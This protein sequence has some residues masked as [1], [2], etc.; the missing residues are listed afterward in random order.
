M[1]RLKFMGIVLFSFV[2]FA[3]FA[4]NANTLKANQDA[5]PAE[6]PS[7]EIGD[8]WIVEQTKKDI[9]SLTPHWKEP[10]LWR[11]EVKECSEDPN[12]FVLEIGS[13]SGLKTGLDVVYGLNP[14]IVK[15]I[16][17]RIATADGIKVVEQEIN[18]SGPVM[19][20]NSPFSLVLPGFPLENTTSSYVEG[21]NVKPLS[22]SSG[23]SHASLHDSSSGGQMVGVQ[24][25]LKQEVSFPKSDDP[26]MMQGEAAVNGMKGNI[27]NG[28]MDASSKISITMGRKQAL[29]LWSKNAPWALVEETPRIKTILIE[30]HKGVTP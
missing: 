16:R 4:M 10:L 3:I 27:A 17:K 7:W 14:W 29:Q 1:V 22:Q 24:Y 21:G 26:L 15:K 30:S 23:T 18:S 8:W 19:A 28:I 2:A 6:G 25:N 9:A 12:L 13:V 5:M 11:C 20:L